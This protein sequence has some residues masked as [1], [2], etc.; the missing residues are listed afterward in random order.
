MQQHWQYI[1]PIDTY[2]VHTNGMLH[3]YDR[4]IISL[5]YQPLIGARATVL[6]FTLWG[7]LE[8]GRVW[9]QETSH[10][11]LM[12]LLQ[13]NLKEIYHERLKLEGIGLL[14]TYENTTEDIKKFIYELR[15]PLSPKEFFHDGVLNVYLYN[16]IGKNVYNKLRQIFSDY[17]LDYDAYTSITKSFNEV[18]TSVHPSE[19]TQHSSTRSSDALELNANEEFS[20]RGEGRVG[21][22]SDSVFDF[23]AFLTSLSDN[24]ISAKTITTTAKE[25]IKKLAFIYGI[26]PIDMKNI[27]LQSL[28]ENESIDIELLRKTAREWYQLEY[29]DT[30]PN[31]VESIQPVPLQVLHD[32]QLTTKEE[33][34]IRYLETTSPK[35][36][37]EDLSSGAQASSADLRVI[38]D[39]MFKQK[40]LPGV[41][42]VLIHYVLLK[43]NMKLSKSYMEKIASH[44]VRKNVK[45]VSEAM[46]LAKAE[47]R[48]YQQW[49]STTQKS[50]TKTKKKTATPEKSSTKNIEPEVK[51]KGFDESKE[52]KPKQSTP[53]A[54][55]FEEEKRKLDE[56][57]K[58]FK[59]QRK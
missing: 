14:E 4:K 6:Y 57:L 3:D 44:W 33:A 58:T 36:L 55:D 7:E 39:I 56:Q 22:F 32:K 10:H 59:Q 24:F 12:A 11:S 15:P 49:L 42:N 26:K 17:V 43:T 1:V 18:F 47:H 38:E 37:L 46:E 8:G 25:V 35:Q 9:G 16:K 52:T 30:L 20:Y 31:L 41:V 2:R 54:F 13:L 29:G 34:L 45:T 19:L 5:L 51:D 28:T 40:L 23:E 27:V 53:V 50:N 48:E 21:S